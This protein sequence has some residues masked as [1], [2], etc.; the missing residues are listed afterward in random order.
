MTCPNVLKA[1]ALAALLSPLCLP[2]AAQAAAPAAAPVD[3][4]AQAEAIVDSAYRTD[5]PGAA[6]IITR[7][8]KIVYAAGRG[9][10][11]VEAHKPITPDTVFSL[12]SIAKQFTAAVILQLV[13]EGRMSLDDPLSKYFPDW[14]QP[15]A[16]ATIRQLLNHTSGIKDY[17]K[18]PGWIPKN[19]SRSFTTGELVAL[20]KTLGSKAEPG[21]EWEYNNGG[22]VIL[23]G[24]VEKVTGKPW[25]Q[26]V[27]DRIARPL[28][29]DSLRYAA[30]A[31]ASGSLAI[32]YGM[33]GGTPQPTP[34]IDMSIAGA[35]GGLVASVRDMAKWAEALHNGK[36]VAPVLYD[37][38]V[39]P[40][41]LNDGSTAPYGFALRLRKIQGHPALEHGGAGRGIDT[42]SVYLP[43]DRVFV[44]AFSNSDDLPTDSSVVLRRLAA[45]AIGSPLPTFTEARID[46]KTVEPLFGRYGVSGAKGREL[47]FFSRDGGYFISAGRDELRLLPAGSDRFYS[48]S[49]G[50]DWAK[51][52]RQA[53]GSV[54]MELYDPADA[55]PERYA[56][57]GDLPAEIDVKVPA[58]VLQSYVG[59]YQTETLAV[60][61]ALK[62]GA[63]V[64]QPKGQEAMPL[65]P[66][67]N[68]EFMLDGN[69]MRVVFE[70]KDG[71]VDS[72]TLHRGARELHGKRVH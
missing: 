58:A 29:L 36:V 10:A 13:G 69:R 34:P 18:I 72:F 22:Y 3:I 45:L 55:A 52:V 2:T 48:A 47:R 16:R 51:F 63:L 71:K 46:P 44:G 33:D 70:Q 64:M 54:T 32:R 11:D 38:M 60:T 28:G 5:A 42:D 39:R 24:V 21:A 17:S 27:Q 53:D 57:L 50:L 8:G 12:G 35:A 68:T 65:R 4:K 62:D 49:T 7:N 15:G 40:A 20:T 61:V 1:A 56:R 23:G 31:S 37:E 59:E 30:A 26:A 43:A 9:L 19:S 14:P 6:A 25:Y 67:S 41:K 66:V